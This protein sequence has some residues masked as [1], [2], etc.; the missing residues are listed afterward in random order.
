MN[1]ANMR[2]EKKRMGDVSVCATK[3]LGAQTQRSLVRSSI[4]MG[5]I[6][7]ERI[8]V[9][10]IL[11][12]CAANASHDGRRPDCKYQTYDMPLSQSSQG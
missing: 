1:N 9:Y 7:R 6:P 2:V 8:S 10:T 3:L 12:K 11:K 5:L 4:G